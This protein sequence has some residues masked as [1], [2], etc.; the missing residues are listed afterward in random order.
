LAGIRTLL[1]GVGTL[2]AG[3]RT[4]LAGVGTLLAGIRTLLAG[5]GTLL[6]GRVCSRLKGII[7]LGLDRQHRHVV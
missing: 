2:L 3:I 6:A 4:L 7:S 1:A 5:V